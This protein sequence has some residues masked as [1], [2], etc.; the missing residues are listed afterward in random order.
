MKSSR[1]SKVSECLP[2]C[3]G[4]QKNLNVASGRPRTR[5]GFTLTELMVVI[6]IVVVLASL[7][8]V[9]F[10][11]MKRKAE[12]ASCMNNLRQLTT[13]AFAYSADHSGDV[14][15]PKDVSTVRAWQYTLAPEIG[16]G[17]IDDEEA[18]FPVEQSIMCCPTQFKLNPQFYTYSINRQLDGSRQGST[19]KG[20][21]AIPTKM[22]RL[23]R[24]G[25]SDAVLSKI[26][27][28]MDGHYRAGDKYT[29]ARAWPQGRAED[30]HTFPH[31][32]YCN[33][34]FMDGHVEA[35]RPNEGPF[36]PENR[37]VFDDGQPGF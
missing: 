24:S 1:M 5:K 33:V 27:Y 16:I 30:E 18:D 15:M 12:S 8:F 21:E 10:G 14:P 22:I 31:N 36:D 29:T 28:F 7:S 3:V 4:G 25:G 35:T 34:S 19:G 13:V 2:Q 11:R 6:V 26:P 9:A 32:G 20:Q 17:D 23:S 37:P